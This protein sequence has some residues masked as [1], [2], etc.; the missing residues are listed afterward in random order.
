MNNQKVLLHYPGKCHSKNKESMIRMCAALNIRYE[1]TDNIE[2]LQ[3]DRYDYLWLPNRWISP[4][5]IP[6]HVKILYGPEFFVIP[7]GPIIGP[8]NPKWAKR[9][10]YTSLSDWVKSYY[11]EFIAESVI[12]FMPFPFGIN[13]RIED[14]KKYEKGI[15]C[16]VYSKERNPS[17][18][19]FIQSILDKHGLLYKIYTYGTYRNQD[20]MEDLKLVRF[21]VWVGMYESQGFAFQETLASNVPIL[22]YDVTSMFQYYGFW[23]E[24]LGNKQM[25]AT[26]APFWS[27][28]CGERFTKEE[29]CET[30]LLRIQEQLDQYRPREEILRVNE[31][32]VA[33]KRILSYFDSLDSTN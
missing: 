9:C 10:V 28:L 33:M 15:D 27:P 16:I 14:T 18:L 23:H 30:A 20:Y 3:H 5:R 25:L 13:A 7:E 31:D 6:E 11:H 17:D 24:Y 1:V 29:E 8:H 4:D 19:E 26:T 2:R 21:V 32:E 22:C 12:P